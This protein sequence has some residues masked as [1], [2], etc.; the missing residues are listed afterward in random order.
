MWV[1]IAG[2]AGFVATVLLK[3][4]DLLVEGRGSW[5]RRTIRADAELFDGL[6]EEVQ[7][8]VGGAALR[9]RI[10]DELV[11]FSGVTGTHSAASDDSPEAEAERQFRKAVADLDLRVTAAMTAILIVSLG[12]WL[13]ARLEDFSDE[14]TAY[15]PLQWVVLT[16][17]GLGMGFAVNGMMWRASHGLARRIVKR[18]WHKAGRPLPEG[19]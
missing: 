18:R 1:V 15:T 4:V 6:P 19:V 2:I 13:L 11:A 8:G 12:T 14:H 5:A 3:V 7:K 16:V 9:R 17:V 10:D